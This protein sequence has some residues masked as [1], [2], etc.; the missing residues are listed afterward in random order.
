[1]HGMSRRILTRWEGLTGR[2]RVLVGIPVAWLVLFAFH[3]F[4]PLLSQGD[5][6]LYATMEAVP[7]ALVAA[8]ATQNELR[9]RA[10]R[11]ELL[12]AWQAEHPGEEWVD[13]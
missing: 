4:F 13:R 9:R 5:R 1:M 8:W 6:A 7:I 3:Q 10:E 2:D 11:A 12:A